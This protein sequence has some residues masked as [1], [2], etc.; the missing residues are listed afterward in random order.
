MILSILILTIEERYHYLDP[1]LKKLVQQVSDLSKKDGIDYL[2]LIQILKDPRG[3]EYTKGRKRND[4][5]KTSEGKYVCFVDD[6]DDVSHDYIETIIDALRYNPDC[7]SLR[8]EMTTDGRNPQIFEHSLKYKE[9]RETGNEIKYERYP[10]HL[11]VIRADVAKQFKFPEINYGE[12]KKWSDVVHA[13][14][15]L[16]SEFYIDKVL[17]YYKY[18][19][20][21]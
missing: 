2:D 12:D 4:L 20:K 5:L 10:N 3:K 15:L 16:K 17:Y 7:L 19:T 6:D 18:V 1:L 11:N 9:W 14:G 13:S 8:G 21:K